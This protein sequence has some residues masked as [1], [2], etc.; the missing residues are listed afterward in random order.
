MVKNDQNPL[1]Y[2]FEFEKIKIFSNSIFDY[3]RYLVHFLEGCDELKAELLKA[4]AEICLLCV[5]F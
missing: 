2:N 5:K 4:L 1:K 3:F